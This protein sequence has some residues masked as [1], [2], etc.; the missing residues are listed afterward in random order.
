M[1]ITS[2]T[3]E[4]Q[5]YIFSRTPIFHILPNIKDVSH[6]D[7]FSSVRHSEE[8]LDT[9]RDSAD[10]L[11]R[12]S[13]SIVEEVKEVYESLNNKLDKIDNYSN[14]I[15]QLNSTFE[16]KYSVKDIKPYDLKSKNL[17]NYTENALTLKGVST[18][19]ELQAYKTEIDTTSKKKTFF[20]TLPPTTT[21]NSVKLKK[22]T[23]NMDITSVEF[24]ATSKKT[25][26]RQQIVSA[27]NSLELIIDIPLDCYIMIV[28]TICSNV[29]WNLSIIPSTFDY[30]TTLTTSLDKEVYVYTD[31]FSIQSRAFIPL[32]C[33]VQIDFEF[34]F[35][36]LNNTLLTQEFRS[37]N[38]DNNGNLVD[39]YR[40]LKEDDKVLYIYT[41][42]VRQ[43]V[44]KN[45][46]IKDEDFVIYTP[47]EI[48]S[49][50]TITENTFRFNIKNAKKVECIPTLK[51]YSLSNTK[52]TPK[53]YSLIGIAKNESN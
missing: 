38:I 8:L 30:Q 39:Y 22:E 53:L 24:L 28:E 20:F 35:Y 45:T 23:V 46:K 44:D 50:K 15:I 19:L 25:I 37:L 52:L 27:E 40:N 4:F 6:T 13:E 10:F 5:D 18:N 1:S 9:F 16:D 12:E 29:L 47:S 14:A 21:Y 17:W 32:D 26:K 43:V 49:V 42:R 51:L 48:E 7:L 41:N 36:D 34:L 2:F 11:E 33:Y 31:F 3:Q